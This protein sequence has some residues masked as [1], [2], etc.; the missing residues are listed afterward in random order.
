MDQ[1]CFLRGPWLLFPE[2]FRST[3]KHR[4]FFYRNSAKSGQGP[5]VRSVP[6]QLHWIF[7]NSNISNN[8]HK[9][10]YHVY[11]TVIPTLFF[12]LPWSGTTSCFS[13]VRDTNSDLTTSCGSEQGWS[14]ERGMLRSS[15]KKF[16]LSRFREFKLSP[17]AT[18]VRDEN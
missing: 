12:Q 11:H 18:Y 5:A 4:S 1:H 9:I 8:L 2:G 13:T 14:Q 7:P 3:G 16:T 10:L 15:C 6:A 17:F